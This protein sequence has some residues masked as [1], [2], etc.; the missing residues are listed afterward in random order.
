MNNIDIG[1][2]NQSIDCRF[3]ISPKNAATQKN[4]DFI[5]DIDWL[6]FNSMKSS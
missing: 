4:H 1:L 3:Y 2:E 6:S 5:K